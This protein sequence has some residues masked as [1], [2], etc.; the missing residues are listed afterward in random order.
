MGL[1]MQ[2]SKARKG[3]NSWLAAMAFFM[4]HAG[5]VPIQLWAAPMYYTLVI[6]LG[7]NKKFPKL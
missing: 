6:Y 1:S 3:A 4:A 2:W 7:P 5:L